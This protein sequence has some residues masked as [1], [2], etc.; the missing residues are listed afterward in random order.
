[1]S[2]QSISK[3]DI[4]APLTES[5][6]NLT[7]GGRTDSGM[8]IPD[9]N[10]TSNEPFFDASASQVGTPE[11]HMQ[12]QRQNQA[13]RLSS[14]HL[15]SYVQAVAAFRRQVQ[16]M[17]AASEMFARA[18]EA[19][20]ETVP[21]SSSTDAY[22]TDLDLLI[23]STHLISNSHQI[24]AEGLGVEVEDPLVGHLGAIST[25]AKRIEAANVGKIEALTAQL[26]KEEDASYKLGKKK[27]RDLNVLQNVCLYSP[28]I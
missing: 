12:K 2:R 13:K 22:M 18:C 9:I 19:L 10:F 7:A 6:K 15:Q 20:K 23:D 16:A 11:H 24:W 4:S 14:R 28:Y 3:K 8:Q 17:G 26:H 5:F 25:Q 21:A 27:T 1:M